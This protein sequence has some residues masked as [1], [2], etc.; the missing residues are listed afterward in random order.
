MQTLLYKIFKQCRHK[1]IIHTK[2]SA[3]IKAVQVEKGDL[4]FALDL[5][6]SIPEID[7]EEAQRL[8]DEAYENCPLTKATAGQMEVK[9]N[10][11]LRHQIDKNSA[12]IKGYK[13]ESAATNNLDTTSEPG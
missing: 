3:R 8:L 4:R 2:V 10:L 1:F 6:V 7:K 13:Q 11:E 12:V 9:M 5:N